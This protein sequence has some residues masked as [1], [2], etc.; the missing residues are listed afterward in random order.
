MQPL[1]NIAGNPWFPF[2]VAFVKSNINAIY[3]YNT[4]AIFVQDLFIFIIIL[5][6]DF[7]F[8][9]EILQQYT[10]SLNNNV[11]KHQIWIVYFF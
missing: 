11:E 10:Q 9:F 6:V 5:F 3:D 7:S 2:F 1:G 4:A 8:D